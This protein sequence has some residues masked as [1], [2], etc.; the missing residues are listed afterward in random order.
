VSNAASRLAAL[1]PEKKKLLEQRLKGLSTAPAAI[2]KRPLDGAPELS[3]A[4][5]RLWFL[6]QLVPGNPFYNIFSPL[7]IQFA[8]NIEVL[9]R[10]LNEI[11]RRHE[12][13]RTT[14]ASVEGKP[15]Q[16]IAPSLDF[17]MP[18]IDLATLPSGTREGEAFR[19]A[20]EEA[21]KPF[22]LAKGPLIRAKLL[23]L[24][25]Q[26]HV[27]L[28]SM[29]HI[30]SDGWSMGILFHELGVLYN[31]FATGR[32]SPLPELPIQY[33]DFAVWQRGYLRGGILDD[34]LSYWRRQLNGLPKLEL[35][36]DR[37]RPAM[38]SFRGSYFPLH[39]P[40]GLA[41][42]LK[43]L[44]GEHDATLFMTMLAAFQ[45]LLH[46]YTGQ[47]DIAVGSPVANRNRSEIEGLIGFFV[48]SLVVRADFSGNP[49][50]ASLLAEVRETALEAYANQ[51]LPFEL[52][53]D[54]LQPDRDLSR[55]PLFQVIFQ[56]MSAPTSATSS[57][58]SDAGASAGP[59]AGS[60]NIQTGTAKFDLNITLW[61]APE[62]VAGGIEFNTDIFDLATIARMAGHYQTLLHGIVDNPSQRI[63]ELPILTAP[64]KR[65][66]LIDWNAT[67]TEFPRHRAL[68]SIFEDHVAAQ[69]DALAVVYGERRLTYQ[70]LN[71]Q[72]NRLAH[73]LRSLGI[74]RESRVGICMDRSPEMIVAVLGVAKAGGAYVPLDSEYPK[75][76]IA[77]MMSDTGLEALI[78]EEKFLDRLPLTVTTIVCLDRYKALLA[79]CPSENPAAITSGDDLAYVMYTSGSTG[80]PKGVCVL[81]RGIARLVLNTDYVRLGRG[82]RIAQVSNFS[83]DAATFEIWGALLNGGQLIGIHKDIL[84]SP[85]DF[86]EALEANHIAAMFLTA[87]LFNQMAQEYPQAFR[88]VRNLLVGGE[89][90]DPK[91]VR[92]VLDA[93]PPQRL[94]NGYGPTETTTFAVCHPIQKVPSGVTSIPIGRPIANTTTYIVNKYGQLVPVGVK[95]ELYIGGPGVAR[96]YWRRDELT[97]ERFVRNPFPGNS[98]GLL[99]RSGDLCRY[100]AD[101]SI[102][103]L[104]RLDHQ[105]KIRGFRIELGEIE[106]CLSQH[107]AV[108]D[109]VVMARED[110][111]GGRR[112]VAY[113]VQSGGVA[114]DEDAQVAHWRKVYDELIYNSLDEHTATYQG[115]LFNIKGWI[116]SYTQEPISPEAMKQQVDKT[117]DRVLALGPKRVL[118]IGC[119]TGLLLSRI[120]P[121]C[122]SYVGTDFSAAALRYLER[123]I[124]RSEEYS[125]ATLLER[126]ADDFSGIEDGSFDVVI[127]NSV[128]Q[129]FPSAD[130][131]VAILRGA[132]RS[133]AAGGA[134]F[135][136]DVRNLRLLEAFHE[137]LAKHRGNDC[138]KATQSMSEEQELVIDPLFF[139]ALERELPE[140][141]TVEIRP[142]RGRDLNEL[143]KFRYD[144]T[145]RVGGKKAPARLLDWQAWQ[146]LDHLRDQL[147]AGVSRIAHRNVPNA[148][149]SAAAG[150]A[151][152]EDLWALGEEFGYEVDIRWD[153]TDD[154]GGFV[155]VCHKGPLAYS[156]EPLS[157]PSKHWRKLTNSPAQ[158]QFAKKLVPQLRSF[159]SGR[160]PEHMIPSAFVLLEELP[161]TPNGKV[162]RAALPAAGSV[163]TAVETDYLAPRNAIEEK[164][165][166]IW[167]EVLGV[168]R[169]GIHDNFF[170]QL[171]GHSLTAT[172]LI[173]RV[174]QRFDIEL[175]IRTL[176]EG[177]TIARL[178]EVVATALEKPRESLPRMTRIT[179]IA[180]PD[181]T[182]VDVNQLSDEQVE[183]MLTKLLAEEASE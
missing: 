100:L 139:Y 84:L 20:T 155:L 83:F 163:R 76:R 98:P 82:D 78:T 89:A 127:L 125:T 92:R 13:L 5:Q 44:S 131:L 151:D 99:Y 105:V 175:P 119:G 95:G 79:N 50:F 153:A 158:A 57:S 34:Q 103:F 26:D 39:F 65:Q 144:V 25:Q 73:H 54:E 132:I 48:N 107:A 87:A 93:G 81:A 29:H 160:L 8:V 109:A 124:R 19:L 145:L 159:L 28:L 134:I 106:A 179:R 147:Q 143:T 154:E 9:R 169:I 15:V 108:K 115:A 129:Y 118:E 6:D 53:V 183:A 174:R 173:S 47:D 88:T 67:N 74:G 170:S 46:H 176:F 27:L 1:T 68:V 165:A 16:V 94:L 168:P 164:L 162:D 35:P 101:G 166:A 7:P 113:I 75:E 182:E 102:E 133:V 24:N 178:A 59:A 90:L 17:E 142:K 51:D 38:P 32:P 149:I 21:R 110:A 58:A 77:F 138:G 135:V 85:Q 30:V 41:L 49:T 10:C 3:F 66:I 97:V 152:P 146:S 114:P 14:F 121:H 45:A 18:V 112:L 157:P 22:D 61:E 116:S 56:L 167:T 86:A 128:V 64:E 96:G 161:L 40:R 141:G 148:R 11:V 104:G 33:A 156:L 130:Y 71:C 172:Q 177:P 126:A 122:D 60:L 69:P 72:A 52:L 63:S 137:S 62:G 123:E 43:R 2:P 55:N 150:A 37:P 91:W 4:Q 140:I 80:I 23:R 120:A 180:A 117:V 31:S 181:E 136:G 12:A 36:T 171:G 42:S 111:E 70:E